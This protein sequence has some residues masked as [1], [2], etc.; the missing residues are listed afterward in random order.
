MLAKVI[1]RKLHDQAN[2]VTLEYIRKQKCKVA[3][4]N[5]GTFALLVSLDSMAIKEQERIMRQLDFLAEE[6]EKGAQVGDLLIN[7]TTK[8]GCSILDPHDEL[9]SFADHVKQAYQGLE[10]AKRESKAI[11]FYQPDHGNNVAKRLA[12]AADLQQALRN[13]ELELYH[14][15]QINLAQQSVDGSEALL[16]WTHPEQGFIPPDVFIQLAEDTGVINELTLWVINKACQQ[17]EELLKQ[18]FNQ[19]NVSINIS[20]KD[21]AEQE[22]MPKVRQILSRYDFPANSLTFELT[23]SV[24]VNDFHHLQQTMAQ[25]SE[26]GVQ[27]AIDDYGTGYSSLFYISQLPFNEIKIDKSFVI[28]LANSERDLT[29]V[30]TTIEMAKSLGLKLVAEGIEN[31][32]IEEVLKQHECHIVQGYYYQKPI[33]FKQ[34]ISW[35]NA[36][37]R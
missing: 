5:E 33:A 27:V 10:L 32:Q 14:Q 20:G 6:M 36:N 29:I 7:L 21:I 15:P 1:E 35:L 24:M 31:Q 12:L 13:D 22:F 17:L 26:L 30:R 9:F 19:H 2:F 8:L 37:A 28:N 34:Y 25:L 18:G 3:K 4:I 16:R 23:E 11:G